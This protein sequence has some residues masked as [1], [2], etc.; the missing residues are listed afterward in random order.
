MK[1]RAI[2]SL[3][4]LLIAGACGRP[5]TPRPVAGPPAQ[6]D[7]LA[8]R[9][10]RDSLTRASED[11]IRAAGAAPV[12][13][14]SATT[15]ALPPKKESATAPERRCVLDLLNTPDTRM[16][17]I[18]DPTTK[19]RFTYLGGGLMGRCRGQSITITADSAESYEGNDLHILIGSVKY[20]EPKY[21]IDADRVTYFRL[22]ERLLFQGNVHA[23]M[24]QDAATLDGPQLEY[25]RPIRG[26]RD[27]ERVVATQRPKLTYIEK[28]S[29]GKDQPPIVV[30]GN[31]ILGE[32]DSTFFAMGDV[33]IERT[34]SEERRVG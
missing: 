22:E 29:A 6:A 18:V 15:P 25:F 3:A 23:V 21:A 33:R 5:G 17:A 28:D 2:T 1:R 13:P 12:A 14:P 10:R 20:R 34:R 16:N 4:I 11:S 7:T 26:L 19:K 27:K 32:G 24:T 9:L 31:T 30:L 8:E